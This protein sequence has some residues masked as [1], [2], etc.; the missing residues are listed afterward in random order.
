MVL[1][2]ASL[3]QK[4][5]DNNTYITIHISTYLFESKLKNDIL[6][7]FKPSNMPE[8]NELSQMFGGEISWRQ[9]IEIDEAIDYSDDEVGFDYSNYE[10][11]FNDFE[12][13]DEFKL[14][15]LNI[16]NSSKYYPLVNSYSWS[17][18]TQDRY[19]NPDFVFM[20]SM[21]AN[22]ME[23]DFNVEELSYFD[24]N[25]NVV[26]KH[27]KTDNSEF[28]FIERENLEK[29]LTENNSDLIW[30]KFIA[31]HGEFGINQDKKLDPSYKGT[32]SIDFYSDIVTL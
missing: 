29:F 21:I 23:L 2:Y 13:D 19:Q 32:K 28:L 11:G 8:L 7:I 9:H 4:N 18:W 25:G 16:F 24:K 31:K 3:N 5:E 22:K 1:L 14:E 17:S 30:N 26:T 10:D 12:L 27:Y 20:N 6:D 15:E